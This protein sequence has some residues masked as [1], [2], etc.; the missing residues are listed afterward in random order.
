MYTI[1]ISIIIFNS[2]FKILSLLLFK[3]LNKIFNYY[4]HKKNRY[5]NTQ[6]IISNCVLF[7]FM[8]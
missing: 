6:L 4:F 1:L 3:F 8:R 7:N 5:I 2:I